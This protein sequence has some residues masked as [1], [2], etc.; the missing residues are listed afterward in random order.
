M[1]NTVF[2]FL[3]ATAMWCWDFYTR[4]IGYLVVGLGVALLAP[5][6]ATIVESTYK[7][8]LMKMKKQAEAEMNNAPEKSSNGMDLKMSTALRSSQARPEGSTPDTVNVPK[9]L[10]FYN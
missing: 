4:P 5:I 9:K 10:I 2:Q 7:K 6:V 8:K 1:C 3:D